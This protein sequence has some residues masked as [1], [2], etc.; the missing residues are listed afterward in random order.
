MIAVDPDE[1]APLVLVA[2]T[3]ERLHRGAALLVC[4]P[5]VPFQIRD[6]LLRPLRKG[7]YVAVGMA[8]AVTITFLRIS[9]ASL[10]CSSVNMP[11]WQALDSIPIFSASHL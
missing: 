9:P 11:K 3:Q 4:F 2:D 1:I 8:H 6:V 10:A 5:G 7:G